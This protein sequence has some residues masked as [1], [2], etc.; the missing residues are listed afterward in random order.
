MNFYQLPVAEIQF[1]A[2]LFSFLS[3]ERL[4]IKE[5]KCNLLSAA[6]YYQIALNRKVVVIYIKV[7]E[8]HGL[9]VLGPNI[10]CKPVPAVK[11]FKRSYVASFSN[12]CLPS[13]QIKILQK[14]TY[15]LNAQHCNHFCWK[16]VRVGGEPREMT[17]PVPE[18]WLML[19]WKCIW[20]F[21]SSLPL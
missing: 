4:N 3:R 11:K 10:Y 16:W 1:C 12:L 5:K 2:D 20:A 9:V 17:C 15:V 21:L 19:M 6:V 14:H 7:S 13:V 18:S 8:N